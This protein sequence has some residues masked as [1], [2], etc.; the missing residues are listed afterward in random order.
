MRVGARSG[1]ILRFLSVKT[2]G[3]SSLIGDQS[4]SW[5]W[6]SDLYHPY[7]HIRSPL[8]HESPESP[9]LIR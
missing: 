9:E 1:K 6:R 7:H 2:A 8:P 3:I 5:E 4:K